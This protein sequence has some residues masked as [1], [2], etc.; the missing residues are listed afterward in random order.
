[1]S[2]DEQSRVARTSVVPRAD[3]AARLQ[4]TDKTKPAAPFFRNRRFLFFRW[5]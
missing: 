5:S 2:G 3:V 4:P 1:M